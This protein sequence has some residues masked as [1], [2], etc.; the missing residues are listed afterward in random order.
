MKRIERCSLEDTKHANPFVIA[1]HLAH[2]RLVIPYLHG[3]VLD[4]GSSEGFGVDMM[5]RADLDAWGI[6]LSSEVVEKTRL[7]YGPYFQTGSITHMPFED[8]SFDAVTC[9]EVIEHVPEADAIRALNE[10]SR[11][12]RPRGQLVLS[13]PNVLISLGA[14]VNDYHFR[15][16]TSVEMAALLHDAGFAD[17]NMFGLVCSNKAIQGMTHSGVARAWVKFKHL[18]G[19]NRPIGNLGH[20]MEKV[21]T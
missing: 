20:I 7:R 8:D 9:M 21:L 11:V 19:L 3:R 14:E 15:E 18:I 13:T 5:R 6:D 1:E 2:Y 10:I 12:L 4:A 17:V 16:Y